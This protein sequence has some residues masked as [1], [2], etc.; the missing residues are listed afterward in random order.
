MHQLDFIGALLQEKVKNRVFVK[1]DSRYADCFPEYSNYPGRALIL[2]KSMYGMTNSG[3]IFSDELTKWLLESGF[4]K[5][6]CQMY[7]YDKYALYGTKIVV[8]FYVDDCVYWYTSEAIQK[9]FVDALGK[10]FHVNFL[11]CEHWFMSIRILQMRDH[12]ISVYQ[13]RYA[14]SIVVNTWMLPQLRRV[15]IFYNTT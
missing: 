9:W 5:P 14:T 12:S 13:A 4:I 11:G 10:I 7:I 2:L 3:N 1:V 6:Q 8:L 15:Q